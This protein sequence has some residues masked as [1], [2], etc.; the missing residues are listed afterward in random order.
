M[1]DYRKFLV[2]LS[3]QLYVYHTHTHIYIYINYNDVREDGL[4]LELSL[5]FLYC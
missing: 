4:F 2:Y 3:M 1:Y 5:Y